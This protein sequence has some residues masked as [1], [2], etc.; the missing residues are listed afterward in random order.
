MILLLFTRSRIVALLSKRCKALIN[1]TIVY[2]QNEWVGAIQPTRVTN[3]NVKESNTS[4]MP[5]IIRKF[6]FEF[7]NCSPLIVIFC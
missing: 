6:R 7:T 1:I 3:I 4:N 5:H 2:E